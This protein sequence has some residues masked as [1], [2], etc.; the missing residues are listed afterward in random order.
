MST[1][2]RVRTLA[3]GPQRGSPVSI[4]APLPCLVATISMRPPPFP[5]AWAAPAP[6]S[7]DRSGVS[8][9]LEGLR[10]GLRRVGLTE[11][12]AVGAAVLVR[13]ARGLGRRHSRLRL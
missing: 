8:T 10:Y 4:G 7:G 2:T 13:W 5:V 12:Q 1:H 9:A 6:P 3:V 11:R